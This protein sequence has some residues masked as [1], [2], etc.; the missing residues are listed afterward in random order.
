M[1]KR[2]L[3]TSNRSSQRSYGRIVNSAYSSSQQNYVAGRVLKGSALEYSYFPGGY[4]DA[5]GQVHYTINDYQGSVVMVVDSVGK[6]EQHNSYYPYGELHRNSSGQRR[7]YIGKELVDE[8]ASYDYGPR[9]F[10]SAGLYW[11]APDI[12]AGDYPNTA[13]YVMCAANPIRNSDPTGMKIWKMN[14]TGQILGTEENADIDGDY[15]YIFNN[16]GEV[17]AKSSK[18]ETGTIQLDE[19]GTVIDPNTNE[20]L[21]DNEGKKV[22]YTSLKVKG[23]ES[24]EQLFKF[25]ASEL[26]AKGS[27]IEF[28]LIQV[29]FEGTGSNFITTSHQKASEAGGGQLYRNKLVKG[30]VIRSDS[31]SHPDNNTASK[32]DK[33]TKE[34][35]IKNQKTKNTQKCIPKFRVLNSLTNDFSEY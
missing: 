26:T 10:R 8:T 27:Y 7:M 33:D 6:V 30:Y 28:S 29:G 12:K 14:E 34:Q 23:D 11:E 32:T 2:S 22:T 15:I 19:S 16:D 1:K 5:E 24:G 4:F 13:P 20:P 3:F 18:H 35:F 17:I 31:H 25:L 9:D 21:K